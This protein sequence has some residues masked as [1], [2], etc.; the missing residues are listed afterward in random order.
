MTALPKHRMTVDEYLA[1]AQDQPGRYELYA[2]TVYAMTPERSGHAEVKYA[3]QTALLAGIRR[4]GLPCHM[5]PDGM[6]VRVDRDTAHE[7][8]ALV[9]CG[10]KVPTST[11]EVPN[12]VIVVEVLSPSTRGLDASYKLA[13]YFRV[14][15]VQHYLLVDP[16]RPLV[17]HHAR[18]GGDTIATRI[19]T[20]GV[21]RLDP[22]GIDLTV[23]AL[24][25]A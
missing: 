15:S 24:Y 4:A 13:G 23:A 11:V 19:V 25:Q 3:V 2:G 10:E 9:Y 14:P 16:D 1:W 22:P 21:L 18:G 8:D 12:P 7:P 6:T 5:L 20:A 17:I